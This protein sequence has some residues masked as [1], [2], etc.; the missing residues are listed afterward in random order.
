MFEKASAGTEAFSFAGGPFI[1][2]AIKGA[3][4]ISAGPKAASGLECMSVC[5]NLE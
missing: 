4:E 1:H 2:F 3:A 5:K